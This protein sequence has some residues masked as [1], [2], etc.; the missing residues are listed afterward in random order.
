[1]GW[2][3]AAKGFSEIP[4]GRSVFGI[5][6]NPAV[7]P[8]YLAIGAASFLCGGFLFKFFGGHTDVVFSK[9]LRSDADHNGK[10]SHRLDTHNGRFGMRSV[11]KNNVVIFPFNYMSMGNIIKKRE[12]GGA[13]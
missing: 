10:S 13:S 7:V 6:Y 8:L 4:K 3:N 11:N 5:W 1:M 9:S 2:E 12:A